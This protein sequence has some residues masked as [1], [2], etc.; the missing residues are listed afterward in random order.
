MIASKQFGLVYSL[1]LVFDSRQGSYSSLYTS[2]VSW[3]LL[4]TSVW[5]TRG[6][7]ILRR[8]KALLTRCFVFPYS[9]N[10][11]T[12][13]CRNCDFGTNQSTETQ[14]YYDFANAK[15]CHSINISTYF[16]S[17]TNPR[18]VFA[19]FHL[20]VFLRNKEKMRLVENVP[21]KEAHFAPIWR[22]LGMLNPVRDKKH[23]YLY[24]NTK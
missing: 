12:F 14:K 24:K 4:P 3:R 22:G 2:R 6:P 10:F 15:A 8:K 7:H 5:K 1:L 17:S 9:A 21:Y 16:C 11:W 13:R 20:F 18:T 23:Q 19:L